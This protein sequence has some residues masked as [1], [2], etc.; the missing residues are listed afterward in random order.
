MDRSRRTFVP[1]TERERRA[2]ELGVARAL[3]CAE[4]LKIA[5]GPDEIAALLAPKLATL[6]HERMIV[7]LLGGR[8]QILGTE[9]VSVGGAHGCAVMARDVLRI[10]LR[11]DRA[12]GFALAHNHPSGDPTPSSE[13]LRMTRAI[14]EAARIVGL[15]C[16]DHVIVA[17]ALP[18]L[19]A[20]PGVRFRALK[21]YMEF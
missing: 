16:M 9:V 10:A 1:R 4:P 11:A 13:D 20:E 2:Y 3:R 18:G 15:P 8:L 19:A 12:A 21:D 17:G 14:V 6:D 5:R 7:V